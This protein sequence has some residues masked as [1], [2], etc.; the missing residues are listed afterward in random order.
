MLARE[1]QRANAT[2]SLRLAALGLSSVLAFGSAWCE[3]ASA[4]Q[5]A[6]PPPAGGQ[7]GAGGNQEGGNR[8]GGGRGGQR[9]GGG[10][11]GGG[12]GRMFG[13]FGGGP[14]GGPGGGGMRD[15]REQLD[16]DFVRRDV[17]IFVE[18]L[19]LDKV[20]TTVLETVMKDYETE[21]TTASSEVQTQITELGQQ[22]FQSV[23]SPQMRDRMQDQ[24]QQ[25]QD[26]LRQLR[27]EKGGELD[28]E[29]RRQFFRDRMQKMQQEAMEERKTSG[30]D[31]EMKKVLGQM[32][33]KV[34]EW[35]THKEA[36]RTRFVDGLKANLNDDQLTQWDAFDRF[37]RRE[38]TLPKGR[39]SGEST[40]LFFVLDELKL[41]EEEF[42]K[43][44]P[45]LDEYESSLDTALKSRN[46]YLASSAPKL[47]KSMQEGDSK[48]ATRV[49]ERQIELRTAVRNVNDQYRQSIVN[50]LGETE[51]A[52]KFEKAALE[53]GYDRVYR[54][55]TAERAF[56]K[57]LE[58]TDLDEGVRT[59]IVELQGQFLSEMGMKNREILAVVQKN[60]PTQQSADATRFVNMMASMINGDMGFMNGQGGPF[61]D[62]GP[63]LV[64]EA[65]DTRREIDDKYIERLKALLTPEQFAELPRREQRGGQGGAGGGFTRMME[66]MPEEVRA[67]LMKRFDKN[68][69]GQL[70]ETERG[71][72]F[73]SMRDE[74]GRGGPGGGQGG[75]PGGGPGG[76]QG[77]EGGRRGNRNDGN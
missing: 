24:M 68:S 77:G 17:P 5:S 55:S 59:S 33:E 61:G 54:A 46:D 45:Q 43:V 14:G 20:Q 51:S 30:A 12:M 56:A 42:A 74:F 35:M 57:A 72:A 58:F 4:R 69:D 8:D 73:R 1:T 60:E 29:T 66:N 3:T 50:A 26:E 36:M 37:L 10:R 71:E 27:E 65:L 9:D 67:D 34:N 16:P 22:L 76:G 19:K 13:G 62:R 48:E 25:V 18:Q 64:R 23:I 6:P 40:N 41:P 39:L 47:F 63:D 28:E 38:K 70:D 32:F 11:R 2:L 53:N 21:F 31:A 49:M 75:G 44:Q 52:K 15:L 7:G